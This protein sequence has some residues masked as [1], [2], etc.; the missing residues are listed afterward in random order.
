M[1]LLFVTLFILIKF[2]EVFIFFISEHFNSF[3]ALWSTN[4]ILFILNIKL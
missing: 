2:I 3:Q 1:N 4:F